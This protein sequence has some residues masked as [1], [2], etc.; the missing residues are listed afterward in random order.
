MSFLVQ[1]EWSLTVFM[2]I[3]ALFSLTN[4]V[5]LRRLGVHRPPSRWPSVSVLVPARD[6]ERNIAPCVESLLTLD[7]PEFEVVVLDDNSSDGTGSVLRDLSSRSR[8]RLR[9][10]P[11][12]PLPQGWLGK[13][14]ACHQLSHVAQ[15]DVLLFTDAD[16]VHHP[17]ALRDAVCALHST[18][19]DALS[20]LPRQVVGTWAETLVIP[21]LPW[22]IHT[23]VPFALRRRTPIAVGQFMMFRRPAYE[24]IGG[25][26]AIRDQVVDDLAL[27]RRVVKQ[28]FR[29]AFFNGAHRVQT[30]MYRGAREVCRGL[31][32]NLFPVFRYNVPFLVFVWTWLLWVAWQPLIVLLLKALGTTLPPGIATPAAITVGLSLLTWVLSAARFRLPLVQA[33]LYPVTVFLVATIAGRSLFWHLSGRGEWKGR[34]IHVR[35]GRS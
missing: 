15:N 30:R 9:V 2:A 11:G 13:N 33:L 22:V 23:F 27:A 24:R 14:W 31:A 4:L 35:A 6:E 3:L 34:G 20:T 10:I 28:G 26:A 16:T 25:H 29:W 1:H 5:A 17:H 32:K 7:Y 18:Q 8:G 12:G 21:V 19:S